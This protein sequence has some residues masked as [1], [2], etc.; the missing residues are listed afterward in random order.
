MGKRKDALRAFHE[1]FR[2]NSLQTQQSKR[3][4]FEIISL[5]RE[6]VQATLL[7]QG[8]LEGVSLGFIWLCSATPGNQRIE[9]PMQL[10]SLETFVLLKL[11]ADLGILYTIIVFVGMKNLKIVGMEGSTQISKSCAEDC[12]S[13]CKKA[14]NLQ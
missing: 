4:S 2:C 14:V 1:L 6:S 7:A 13:L 5:W 10:Y 12:G 11:K 3:N 9:E 8:H